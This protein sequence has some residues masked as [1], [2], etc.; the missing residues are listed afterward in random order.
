LQD[1]LADGMGDAGRNGG[2]GNV[3]GPSG[4]SFG[5]KEEAVGNCAKSGYS[6]GE[7]VGAGAK[8]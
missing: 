5:K 1:G 2:V 8:L 7:G 3:G 4:M 6:N